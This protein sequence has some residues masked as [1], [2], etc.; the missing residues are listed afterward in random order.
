MIKTWTDRRRN[1]STYNEQSNNKSEV[2]AYLNCFAAGIFFATCLLH[3]IPEVSES[4]KEVFEVEYPVAECTAAIGFF[5]VLMLEQLVTSYCIKVPEEEP[6]NQKNNQVVKN[7]NTMG[8]PTQVTVNASNGGQVEYNVETKSHDGDDD[9][10]MHFDPK[11]Q[12]TM[13]I[14]I[15]VGALSLHAIFE[16]LVF[17]LAKRAS[18][19]IGSMAAVLIH[20]SIIAFSTGMQL[21]T[22]GLPKKI[23]CTAI[24][25]F[26][27][28]APFGVCIGLLITNI[29]DGNTMEAP[30]VVLESIATGTFL[31]VTFL[32]LVPHE[33]IGEVRNGPL[34]VLA[35]AFGFAMMAAF[36]ALVPEH[37][38]EDEG[39]EGINN[40][41]TNNLTT[42]LFSSALLST[43]TISTT[44][45]N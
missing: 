21:M 45:Q 36:M 31:Y 38:E 10:H 5:L 33:F 30:I 29:G 3:M 13:R 25:I 4:M 26:S 42:S 20:K 34:K 11:T 27:F 8:S 40:N 37:G 22:S 9:D 1:S 41:V 2:I 19:V 14:L 44:V 7:E 18:D 12:S 15:L 28:M 32:E 39:A 24:C 43:T 35:M 6:T 16:G 17:G 23:L